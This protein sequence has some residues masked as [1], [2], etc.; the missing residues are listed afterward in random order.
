MAIRFDSGK[1][2]NPHLTDDG[3]LLCDAVFA[4]DGVL[5]YKAPGGK[6]R[7]EFR[8]PE[9][10]Q[11]AIAEF[12]LSSVTLEHPS[13]LIGQSNGDRLRKGISLQ[14][15]EY[16]VVPGKGGFVKGQI[17]VMSK[18][19]QE[20]V[21]RGDASELSAGYKCRVEEKPGAW[22]NPET[23]REERYDAIQRDIRVNHIALTRQG[24]AGPS[25]R[26][27]ARFDSDDLDDDFAYQISEQPPL[28]FAFHDDSHP[29]ETMTTNMATLNLPGGSVQ[30]PQEIF[31]SISPLLSRSDSAV[32]SLESELADAQERADSAEAALE[33]VDSRLEY[34]DG[35][36]AALRDRLDQAE[37]ILEYDGIGWRRDSYARM[38][39]KKGKKKPAF[40]D[41]LEDDEEYSEDM[42]DDGEDMDGDEDE[43]PATPKKGKKKSKKDMAVKKDSV[44]SAA[45]E[46]VV[47]IRD[48][49]RLGVDLTGL[50]M[51]SVESASDIRRFAVE[52]LRPEVKLDGKPEAYI[53]GIYDTLVDGTDESGRTDSQ[54]TD[55]ADEMSTMLAGAGRRNGS[56]DAA[57]ADRARRMGNH[58]SPLTANKDNYGRR[59]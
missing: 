40:L 15:P 9:E 17:A 18:D 26:V 20:A 14:T 11:K 3:I 44:R 22:L 42:D 34:K 2:L 5:E 25:V 32:E 10:N 12:G 38:D 36:I 57:A 6:V 37:I 23:G 27:L 52:F 13:G 30:V 4:R 56:Q 28:D 16:L 54:R 43:M 58:K 29:K 46:M 55:Y 53:Q 7:R 24:R 39:G 1:V 45:A 35:M 41:E 8:P 31:N 47:A 19:A 33:D 48:A 51:D 50:R 59:R 21:K 49:E